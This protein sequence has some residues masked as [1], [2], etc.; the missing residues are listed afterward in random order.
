MIEPAEPVNE[1]KAD[2]ATQQGFAAETAM[3]MWRDSDRGHSIPITGTSM[4]PLLRPGDHVSTEH[5]G[6]RTYR[7]DVIV[8]LHRGGLV[9][10]RVLCEYSD[11]H[12]SGFITK[13]DNAPEP[14]PPVHDDQVLGRVAG[15]RRGD[16]FASLDGRLWRAA[17]WLIATGSLISIRLCSWGQRIQ[18]RL[19]IPR[20]HR[21]APFLRQCAVA[22]TSLALRLVGAVLCRWR[23]RPRPPGI[24]GC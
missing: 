7:G 10:H 5:G 3:R 18:R 23:E 20:S 4:L 17:S 22:S 8:F 11:D 24:E 9:V 6:R 13:G 12:S 21:I 1:P 2:R 19:L 14:D 15:I 16:R